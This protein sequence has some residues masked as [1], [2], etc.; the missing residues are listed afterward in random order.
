MISVLMGVTGK[1]T[2]TENSHAMMETE[3]DIS[4]N[5]KNIKICL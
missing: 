2:Q 1:D 5:P 3:S 4:Y